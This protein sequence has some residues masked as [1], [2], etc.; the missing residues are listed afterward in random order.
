M[1]GMVPAFLPRITISVDR[2]HCC[3]IIVDGDERTTKKHPGCVMIT[4]IP[5]NMDLWA[6]VE[7]SGLP[8]YAISDKQIFITR[9]SLLV[10]SPPSS[11]RAPYW[12]TPTVK[13]TSF[14]VET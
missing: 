8:R 11:T 2:V 10:F 4:T 1:W 6:H 13:C 12:W 14:Q 9:L 7:S 5:C 3:G